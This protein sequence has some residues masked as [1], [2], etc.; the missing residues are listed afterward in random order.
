MKE[1]YSFM[2]RPAHECQKTEVDSGCFALPA[3]SPHTQN[4]ISTYVL[5]VLNNVPAVKSV[6]PHSV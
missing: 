5:C 2:W 1:F 6:N 3:R 4:L